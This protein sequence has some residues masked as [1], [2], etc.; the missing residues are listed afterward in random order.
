MSKKVVFVVIIVFL[1]AIFLVFLIHAIPHIYSIRKADVRIKQT[2]EVKS[3]FQTTTHI[4][5][6]TE[7]LPTQIFQKQLCYPTFGKI[8]IVTVFT[9]GKYVENVV[10]NAVQSVRCYAKLRGYDLYQI[11]EEIDGNFTATSGWIVPKQ[12]LQKDI[13][14]TKKRHCFIA[15]LLYHYDYIVHLD[16]DTGV[17]N[18]NHCFEEYIR[19]GIDIFLL[20][21]VHS[22]EIQA[23][24]YIVKNT[25]YAH[26]F[27]MA[28]FKRMIKPK[29]T[30]NKEFVLEFSRRVAGVMDFASCQRRYPIYFNSVLYFSFVR[31]IKEALNGR[32]LFNKFNVYRRAHGFVRDAWTT[33]FIWSSKDFLL[34]GLKGKDDIMYARK[35]TSEDCS[36]DR[37]WYVPVKT[38]LFANL[39]KMKALWEKADNEFKYK[40]L[41]V[42]QSDI[43]KCWPH[44]SVDHVKK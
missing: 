25:N 15:Y 3:D 38:H 43:S 24:H 16:A 34:H 30:D 36:N 11:Q 37:A 4:P 20:E 12:C 14:L 10:N 18:P 26:N 44:C 9:A 29:T 23:G 35:L 42:M 17:V 21:R 8:A 33:G 6:N 1:Y 7:D 19:P 27:L 28:C 32:M 2:T 40:N 41:G 39:T 13:V 22:G 5:N 31:C